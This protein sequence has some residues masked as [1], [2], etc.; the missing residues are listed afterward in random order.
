[1]EGGLQTLPVVP[2]PAQAGYGDGDGDV[3]VGAEVDGG[4][5]GSAVVRGKLDDVDEELMGGGNAE[6]VGG[7]EAEMEEEGEG[8]AAATDK[9]AGEDGEDGEDTGEETPSK[10]R[11][12]VGDTVSLHHGDGAGQDAHDKEPGDNNNKPTTWVAG[13]EGYDDEGL[14]GELLGDD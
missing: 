9:D 13:N 10:I 4:E 1:V 6:L 7:F 14:D 3:G 2:Q 11:R 8:D 5:G 12:T